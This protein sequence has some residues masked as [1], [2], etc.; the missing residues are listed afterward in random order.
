MGIKYINCPLACPL[1]A[2]IEMVLWEEAAALFAAL[3][4]QDM[5]IAPKR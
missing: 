5:K 4:V 3:L 2:P 1:L